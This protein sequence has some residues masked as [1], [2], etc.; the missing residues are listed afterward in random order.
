[1]RFPTMWYMD[2]RPQRLRPA[3]ACAQSGQ[4]HKYSKSNKLLTEHHLEFPKHMIKGD[5]TGSSEFT[6]VKIFT[7]LLEITLSK[8]AK[9]R[10]RYNQVSHLTQDT[11]GKV[12]S[13]K[14]YTT[15]ENMSRLKLLSLRTLYIRQM[16]LD[17]CHGI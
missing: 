1:M 7:F 10:N 4:S 2:V 15:N 12:T 9:I 3:C 11:N 8:G 13:S 17:F 14:L 5:C 16:L 6:L